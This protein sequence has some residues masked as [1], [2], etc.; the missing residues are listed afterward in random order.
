[1]WRQQP[2]RDCLISSHKCIKPISYNKS[3]L[4]YIY[5]YVEIYILKYVLRKSIFLIYENIC[6]YVCMYICTLLSIYLSPSGFASLVDTKGFHLNNSSSCNNSNKKH[7]GMFFN[8]QD[9]ARYFRHTILLN[10]HNNS[11]SKGYYSHFTYE[12]HRLNEVKSL[13]CHHRDAETD[14]NPGLSDSKAWA[15]NQNT[16][17]L[18]LKT[19]SSQTS[20]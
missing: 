6:V 1:M 17:L 13:D 15:L 18:P 9:C 11:V 2:F 12:A 14:A 7:F 16:V 4:F 10:P 5:N 8:C 20:H 3:L 19:S